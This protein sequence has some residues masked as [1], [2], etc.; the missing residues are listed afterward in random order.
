MKTKMLEAPAELIDD[1]R[2]QSKPDYWTAAL[3]LSE[4]RYRRLFETAHDGILILDANSGEI[5]DVNPFMIDLLQYPFEELRGRK[6][7]DIGEF[8]DIAANRAAFA[9]LQQNEYIRYENLPLRR[10]DGKTIQVEFVSNVYW[11][12]AD[13]VIQCNIRDISERAAEKKNESDAHLAALELAASANKTWVAS[14]L[15]KLRTPLSAM[16]SMLGLVELG[17]KLAE[18]RPLTEKPSEFDE[19]AFQHILRN[20]QSLVHYF[21]EIA[22]VSGEDPLQIAT[23]PPQVGPNSGA[24]STKSANG[25]S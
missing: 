22:A 23:L 6:L 16:A 11:V 12:E 2:R 20:F 9:T 24:L 14:H 19:A 18:V 21:N 1:T 25:Q 17:H 4:L 3:R 5:V 15:Q 13:K 10:R 8:K 7:W